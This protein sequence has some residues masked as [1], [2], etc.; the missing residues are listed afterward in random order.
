MK[1]TPKPTRPDRSGFCQA[2][3][4]R[5]C[6]HVYETPRAFLVCSCDCHT[7]EEDRDLGVKAPHKMAPKKKAPGHKMVKKS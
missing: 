1:S 5:F 3:N 2:G 6:H 7:S 4:H